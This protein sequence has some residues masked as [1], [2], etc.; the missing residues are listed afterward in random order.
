MHKTKFFL[1][2]VVLFLFACQPSETQRPFS[3]YERFMVGQKIVLDS[4]P[5]TVAVSIENYVKKEQPE[6][7]A[8]LMW[9][10]ANLNS[11]G[12]RVRRCAANLE[13]IARDYPK[14]PIVPDA[15]ISAGTNYQNLG[16]MD[17]AK[18]AY[19]QFLSKYPKHA[20]YKEIKMAFA[21]LEEGIS[22]PEEQLEFIRKNQTK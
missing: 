10:A 3:Q 4:I 22:S 15:L 12:G 8:Q 1:G 19:G 11:K 20:M 2:L 9:V 5:D 6:D 21:M 13:T 14:S 16:M 18:K 7:G 17:H